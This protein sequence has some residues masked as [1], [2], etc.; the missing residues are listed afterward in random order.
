MS[1]KSQ[2]L[3]LLSAALDTWVAEGKYRR[4]RGEDIGFELLFREA[5]EHLGIDPTQDL[6]PYDRVGPAMMLVALVLQRLLDIPSPEV[7]GIGGTGT[8]RVVRDE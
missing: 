3:T 2:A 1:A 7:G 6:I 4:A 8:P 5:H